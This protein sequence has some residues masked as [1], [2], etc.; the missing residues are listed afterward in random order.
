[1]N[2]LSCKGKDTSDTPCGWQAGN[3]FS[4]RHAVSLVICP[5]HFTPQAHE[6]FSERL[7]NLQMH[8]GQRVSVDPRGQQR[9]AQWTVTD[10][11]SWFWCGQRLFDDHGHDWSGWL[12]QQWESVGQPVA[13]CLSTPTAVAKRAGA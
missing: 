4:A 7:Y 11:M 3:M 12:A 9:R 1:V 10:Q 8:L 5:V 13:G 2:E 6:S